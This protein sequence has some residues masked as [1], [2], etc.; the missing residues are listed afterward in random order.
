MSE[1]IHIEHDVAADDYQLAGA[2]SNNVKETLK[3]LGLSSSI[4]RRAAIITYE[5]EM[6][7]VIHGGGGR[8][9]ANIDQES[10]EI[11]AVDRGPG[12]PNVELAI[13]EGFTTAGD[14]AREMGFGAGMGLPNIKR[15]ADIFEI[16]TEVGAG[17]TVRTVIYFQHGQ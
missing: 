1:P 3:M 8:I 2:A 15:N 5:A 13:Q 11:M 7:L 16:D 14:R 4:C 10:V 17:T 6:N 9:A 12:I